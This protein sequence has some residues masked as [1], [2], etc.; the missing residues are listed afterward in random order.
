[1]IH[2]ET[3][4][5][6]G[7][8][9]TLMVFQVTLDSEHLNALL[10]SAER[11]PAGQRSVPGH[12]RDILTILLTDT[13]GAPSSAGTSSGDSSSASGGAPTRAARKSSRAKTLKD[14]V[15]ED[16]RDV[17]P[18]DPVAEPHRDVPLPL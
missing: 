3:V 18:V 13:A 8:P 1:M 16:D 14:I 10:E 9:P 6:N 4:G 11:M 5:A 15:V 7:M 17:P 2:A 12:L